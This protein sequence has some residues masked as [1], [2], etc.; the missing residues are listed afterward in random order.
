MDFKNHE[1]AQY[2]FGNDWE[3]TA[4]Q[5]FSSHDT[6][7]SGYI[8]MHEFPAVMY[9]L[10]QKFSQPPPREQDCYYLMQKYDKNSDNKLDMNEFKAM[11][12]AM[13]DGK[14]NGTSMVIISFLLWNKIKLG[15]F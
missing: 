6:N 11:C 15:Y 14:G 10:A 9:E 7:N 1:I 2:N 4:M 5:V 12:K 3:V 13:Q 8:D